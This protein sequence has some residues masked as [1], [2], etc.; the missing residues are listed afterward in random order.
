M[1]AFYPIEQD[2]DS[3]YEDQRQREL[4][5]ELFAEEKTQ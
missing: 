4:D 1:P 2:E 5:E 3:A